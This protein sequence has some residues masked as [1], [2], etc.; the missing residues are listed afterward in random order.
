MQYPQVEEN[1]LI[2]MAVMEFA[3]LLQPL[4]DRV[5]KRAY[6]S[7]NG[8]PYMH[9]ENSWFGQGV[10]L[11]EGWGRHYAVIELDDHFLIVSE[12]PA[13]VIWRQ[14]KYGMK[15]ASPWH[16]PNMTF[17]GHDLLD[18]LKKLNTKYP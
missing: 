14:E 11:R 17:A 10:Y 2:R 15:R 6:V 1:G 13:D 3:P 8:R 9:Y 4:F 12:D 7:D 18:G 16:A 5:G